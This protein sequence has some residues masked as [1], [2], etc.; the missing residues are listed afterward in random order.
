[1]QFCTLPHDAADA[2]TVACSSSVEQ[3]EAGSSLLCCVTRAGASAD[4]D[5]Q[6]KRDAIKKAWAGS[7]CL[8]LIEGV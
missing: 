5:Q 8:R 1:M 3:N 6:K 2:Q 7:G 4:R